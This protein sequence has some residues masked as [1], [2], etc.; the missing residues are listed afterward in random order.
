MHS[1]GLRIRGHLVGVVFLKA[2]VTAA[3]AQEDCNPEH[4]DVRCRTQDL[5][6]VSTLTVPSCPSSLKVWLSI[7]NDRDTCEFDTKVFLS[8]SFAASR[9][10]RSDIG[11]DPGLVHLS[12]SKRT[13][14]VPSFIPVLPSLSCT[15]P[16]G[17]DNV[18]VAV[19]TAQAYIASFERV[20]RTLE[21]C[22]PLQVHNRVMAARANAFGPYRSGR[23]AGLDGEN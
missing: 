4:C 3:H 8:E 1:C 18:A 11:A 12:K 20:D 19:R 9:A 14:L 13:L 23:A 10:R 21:E 16:Q 2:T 17:K 22:W 6:K 5:L 7:L 15:C